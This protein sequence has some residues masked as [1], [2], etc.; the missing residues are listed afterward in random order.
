MTTGAEPTLYELVGGEA[1]FQKLVECF[2]AR[3]EADPILRPMFPADLTPGKRWQQLFLMQYF[4][5]PA[6]YMVERGHPRLR[7]RHNPFPIDQTGRDHWLAH[8][9]AAVDEVGIQEPMRT[10]MRSYFEF[11]STAMINVDISLRGTP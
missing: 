10:T 7:M 2:Y 5:G 8:M 1:T 6:D 4:G 3:V 9:L 11:A